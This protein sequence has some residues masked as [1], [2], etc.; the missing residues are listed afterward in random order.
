MGMSS[1]VNV[2]QKIMV[3]LDSLPPEGLQEVVNFLEYMRFKFQDISKKSTQYKP[4]ALGGLW[5]G[6]TINEKDIQEV[7][8]EMW[9]NLENREL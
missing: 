5:R 2:K 7:R 8:K 1:T 3:S 6:E 4:I 9:Q